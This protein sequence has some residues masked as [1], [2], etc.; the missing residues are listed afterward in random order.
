MPRGGKAYGIVAADQWVHV[1]KHEPSDVSR[2]RQLQ[3]GI[4]AT[5]PG[6]LGPL[7][8]AVGEVALVN[9]Q[10]HAANLLNVWRILASRRIGDIRHAAPRPLQPKADRAPRMDEWEMGQLAASAEL[11]WTR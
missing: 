2:F 10:V 8:A 5:M 9:E 3:H 6:L 1:R 7:F 11:H 4:Q